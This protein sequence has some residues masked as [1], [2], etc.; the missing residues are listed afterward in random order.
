MT[1]WVYF[2]CFALPVSAVPWKMHIVDNT[3]RGADGVRLK[4]VNNDGLLDIATGWEEGGVV[5]A[6]L[7]PGFRKTKQPWPHTEVGKV[8]SPEDAVFTD[9]DGDGHIDV[10]SCCEGR[11]RSVFFH[12]S[13]VNDPQRKILPWRT[14]AVPATVS[15]QSWMFALPLQVDGVGMDLVLGSK[16]EGATIGWLQ[17]PENPRDSKAWKYHP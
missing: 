11:T 17:S 14:T 5:R 2:L 13:P 7:H 16:G 3:S 1:K 6:Y 12:W 10:V 4:D 9:L 15:K 8:K